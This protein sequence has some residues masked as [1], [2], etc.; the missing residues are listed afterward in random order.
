VAKV[1]LQNEV[2]TK[3]DMLELLG[4]RPFDENQT[5]EE[6]IDGDLDEDVSLPSGLKSWN[7]SK[8]K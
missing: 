5:Y 1:L 7:V 8:T 2:I 4:K 3:E 6:L